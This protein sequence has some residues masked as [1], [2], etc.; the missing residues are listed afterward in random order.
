MMC[1]GCLSDLKVE[2][3]QNWR[4]DP[5]FAAFLGNDSTIAQQNRQKLS[6]FGQ[7]LA[8]PKLRLGLVFGSILQVRQAPRRCATSLSGAAWPLFLFPFLCLCL[9]LPSQG[10]CLPPPKHFAAP[11]NLRQPLDLK[12]ELAAPWQ[13]G[14]RIAVFCSPEGWPVAGRL[15]APPRSKAE[16]IARRKEAWELV[17]LFNLARK[18]GEVKPQSLPITPA[19]EALLERFA[20]TD[21]GAAWMREVVD[22]NLRAFNRGELEA[23]RKVWDKARRRGSL[24]PFRALVSGRQTESGQF[25]QDEPLFKFHAIPGEGAVAEPGVI[26]LGVEGFRCE[27]PASSQMVDPHAI[28]S[29]EFGHTRYGDPTSAGTLKGEAKTVLNYENPVRARNGYEPRTVYYARPTENSEKKTGLLK[30][31]LDVRTV[32]GITVDDRRAIEQLHCQCPTPLPLIVDCESRELP[33]VTDLAKPAFEQDCKV[34]L[35]PTPGESSAP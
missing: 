6:S 16:E 22:D 18:A 13:A 9:A 24:P 15:T 19:Q 21:Y 8:T 1:T 31:L 11:P 33:G 2:R 10:A 3:L 20:L 34:R 30:K 35:A 5:F 14:G 7:I 27:F 12:G 25:A 28:L 17:R 4:N 29:H 23:S 32:E 26:G